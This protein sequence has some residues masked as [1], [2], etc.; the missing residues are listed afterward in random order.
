M[1][2]MTRPGR[3]AVMAA[4]VVALLG[5]TFQ[6]AVFASHSWGGYHWARTANPFALKLGDNVSSIWDPHL[7]IASS[8]WS[9]GDPS[10]PDVLNTV[11]VAG[12]ANP[13]NCRPTSGRVEVCNGTYGSNGWLG[14]AQVWVSGS[15]ITQGVVKLNDTYFNTPAYNTPVWRQFVTC[16]EIGHTFG[17]AHQDEVFN[18]P[19]LGSCMDYTSDPTTNQHPN[20]HDF[21]ELAIIYGHVDSTTTLKSSPGASNADLDHPSAWG[22]LMKSSRGGRMQI[23][24]R[25]L[26]NGERVVTFVIWA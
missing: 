9:S 5:I 10:V 13:R 14:I 8:D 11:V 24:E 20:L 3:V 12:Q 21:Q 26:G 18:N 2:C 22:Q 16:Q 17:L 19:N 1:T 15:H 6:F 7:N 25:D 4:L 23:F